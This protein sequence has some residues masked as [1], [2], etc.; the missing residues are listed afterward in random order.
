[1]LEMPTDKPRPAVQCFD[2]A[3]QSVVV[4]TDVGEALLRLCS[5]WG[6]TPF[7]LILA[8]WEL[9]L[10][11]HSGQEEVVVGVPYHGRS[12]LRRSGSWGIS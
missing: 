2:G 9:F 10:C 5:E 11:A 12:L 1:M 8:A 6:A 3:S 4:P 7:Q